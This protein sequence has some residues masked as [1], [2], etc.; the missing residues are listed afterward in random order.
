MNRTEKMAEIK[1]KIIADETRIA[2]IGGDARQLAA[3]A[4]LSNAGFAVSLGGFGSLCGGGPGLDSAL[5][6]AA[7]GQKDVCPHLLP[8]FSGRVRIGATAAEAAEGAEL[9]LLPIPL[10][11]DGKTLL[12]PYS[13]KGELLQTGEYSPKGKLSPTGETITPETVGGILERQKTVQAVIGGGF[14]GAS[15][16]PFAAAVSRSGAAVCDILAS[17]EFA[18]A[19]AAST[20]EGVAAAVMAVLPV[21]VSGCRAHVIGYG[22][23]GKALARLL[24]GMGA[25]VTVYAR[26]EEVRKEADREGYLALPTELLDGKYGAALPYPLSSAAV[27]FNTVP[28]LLIGEPEIRR[29]AD[30]CAAFSAPPPLLADIASLPGG[31][32]KDAAAS[33]GIRVLHELAIPGRAA[34]VSAGAAVARYVRG[35]IENFKTSGKEKE[36]K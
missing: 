28:V 24:R 27:V 3:A 31:I 17:E 21:T 26:R 33:A 32:D 1:T 18:A 9:L 23:T 30:D 22:R 8:L 20:A 19:N 35:V 12:C 25:E 11:R 6:T 5:C 13:T 14:S 10:S 4:E 7:F 15:G 34:P 2:V 16:E 29:I 36:W